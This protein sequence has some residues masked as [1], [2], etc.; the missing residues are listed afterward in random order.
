MK[1]DNEDNNGND[2]NNNQG[3][4][5]NNNSELVKSNVRL[6]QAVQVLNDQLELEKIESLEKIIELEEKI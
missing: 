2:D 6:R 3:N 4:G 5:N 1:G